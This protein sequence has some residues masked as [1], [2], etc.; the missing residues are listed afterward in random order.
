[1]DKVVVYGIGT[2]GSQVALN[3]FLNREI[4]LTVIDKDRVEMR[5]CTTQVYEPSMISASKVDAFNIYVYNR[6]LRSDRLFTYNQEITER[7]P[8]SSEYLVV[9]CFD[10]YKSRSLIQ[11]ENVAHLGFAPDQI[12]TVLWGDKFKA[13]SDSGNEEEDDVCDLAEMR[14]W[15]Q[16]VTGIMTANLLSFLDA[17]EKRSI[18]IDKNFRVSTI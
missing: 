7:Q 2:I 11:G 4:E 8:I 14:Y 16:G 9:D 12:A 6:E 3:L 10:N 15:L 17:G 18:L 13:H 5:N 1:M